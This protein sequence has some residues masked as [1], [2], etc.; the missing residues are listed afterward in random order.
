MQ[1]VMEA[2]RGMQMRGAMQR[3]LSMKSASDESRHAWPRTMPQNMQGLLEHDQGGPCGR[4]RS[5]RRVQR[6]FGVKH[7]FE[8]AI[9][10]GVQRA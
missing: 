2:R 3:F 9:E 4:H 1:M 5:R 10:L 7:A 6:G 8:I